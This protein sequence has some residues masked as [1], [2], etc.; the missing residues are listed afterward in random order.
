[1]K[2]RREKTNAPARPSLRS[3]TTA[4]RPAIVEIFS[5]IKLFSTAEV[6]VALE[7]LDASFVPDQKD[8]QTLGA[9]LEGK[10]VGWVCWGATPCTV[11]TYDM[12]WIAVD[13][14]VHGAGVGSALVDEME[15]RLKGVARLI[16]VETGGRR[17]Y[18][19]TRAFYLARGYEQVARV[20]DFYAPGDDQMVFV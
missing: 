13:P 7:V 10:L 5:H 15:H 12:Y 1:M 3:L 8:Y 4:D 18:E 11:G 16:V 19:P 6:T 14:S 20:P 17:D 2:R 9:D